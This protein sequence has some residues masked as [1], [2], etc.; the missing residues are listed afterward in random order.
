MS[1]VQMDGTLTFNLD[2]TG[3]LDATLDSYD[4][5]GNLLAATNVGVLI[6]N[7]ILSLK[8]LLEGLKDIIKEGTPTLIDYDVDVS[9]DE[10]SFDLADATG[11]TVSL[12]VEAPLSFSFDKPMKVFS[13]ED[14]VSD[15]SIPDN[16]TLTEATLTIEGTNTTGIN[17]EIDATI[18]GKSYEIKTDGSKIN[19]HIKLTGEDVEKLKNE[20][21]PY[22]VE[23]W[24]PEGSYT[25]SSEGELDIKVK[26]EAD[27]T[28]GTK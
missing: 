12:D 22:K 25:L 27:L 21:L 2:V 16:A 8:P 9:V 5:M 14:I 17:L 11:I 19:G 24:L 7:G 4:E 1:T 13:Y 10:I 15:D 6:D 18:N 26:L 3:T 20:G 23:V 28:V